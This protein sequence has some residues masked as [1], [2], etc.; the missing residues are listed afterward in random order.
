ML[1]TSHELHPA[2]V[3]VSSSNKELEEFLTFTSAEHHR[4]PA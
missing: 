1:E 3:P 2:R 4:D